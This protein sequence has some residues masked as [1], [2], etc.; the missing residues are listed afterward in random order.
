[1]KKLFLTLA[2]ATFVLSGTIAQDSSPV[3]LLN[4]N[5]VKKKAEKS[6]ADI[7]DPKKNI[8]AATWFKRG[9]VY[10][11][12]F[13][14]GLEEIQQG[15]PSATVELFYKAP[16][17]VETETLENGSEQQ[18]Y[19]Y[20]HIIYTFVNSGLQDWVKIDPIHIDPLEV[21]MEAYFNFFAKDLRFASF[22]ITFAILFLN[23]GGMH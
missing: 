10:Q 14:L 5:V 23:S 4:Y 7:Q 15:S 12:V 21:A 19:Y 3:V 2:L 22:G 9:E 6:D 8:K 20:E 11:D 13:M 16:T 1:M 18:K 17:K